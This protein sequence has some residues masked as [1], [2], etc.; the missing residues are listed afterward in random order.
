MGGGDS[1]V[2]DVDASVDV[3]IDVSVPDAGTGCRGLPRVPRVLLEDAAIEPTVLALRDD[4]LFFG[5]H[6]VRDPREEPS[7][8]IWQMPVTG[9]THVRLA[10]AQPYYANVSGL[11]LGADYF[12]YHQVAVSP[13]GGGWSFD[14]PAIVVERGD[15]ARVLPTDTLI[16]T[17][18]MAL[19]GDRVIFGRDDPE[20]V[21]SIGL[22]EARSDVE[23]TIGRADVIAAVGSGRNA[24]LWTFDEGE[25]V[26]LRVTAAADIIEVERFADSSSRWPWAAD[27][28]ALYLWGRDSIEAWAIGEE[29]VTIVE[30]SAPKFASVA[31]DDRYLYWADEGAVRYVDIEGGVVQTLV[32]GDTALVQ[33]VATDGCAVYFSVVNP[34]RIMVVSAP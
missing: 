33:G 13:V 34:P 14:Y 23:S 22:Y 27:A 8:G 32:D 15:V 2:V 30:T 9:G 3:G 6:D 1:P 29:P 5:A 24:Y 10:L 31:L 7:S 25:G 16:G 18:G 17:A 26:L 11:L 4:T 19:L 12:A 20:E 28:R 21:G